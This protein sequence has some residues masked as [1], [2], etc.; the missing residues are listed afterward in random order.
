MLILVSNIT[1]TLHKVHRFYN[2]KHHS[3]GFSV[4]EEERE[5]DAFSGKI[6]EICQLVIYFLQLVAYSPHSQLPRHED[7]NG[8]KQRGTLI[9][10]FAR[11][12]IKVAS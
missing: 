12:R 5:K 4:G 3:W 10:K 9:S 8:K 6:C 7:L 2:T 1:K 11:P